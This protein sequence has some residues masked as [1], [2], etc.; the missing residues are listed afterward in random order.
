MDALG[1]K[2]EQEQ[3]EAARDSDVTRICAIFFGTGTTNSQAD[4]SNTQL[5]TML[6]SDVSIILSLI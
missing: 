6:Q 1:G 3:E 5:A 2:A 4:G